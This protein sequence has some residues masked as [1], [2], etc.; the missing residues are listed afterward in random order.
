M[1]RYIIDAQ[2]LQQKDFEFELKVGMELFESMENTEFS[3]VD[4]TLKVVGNRLASNK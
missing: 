3:N 1:K 4:Y 2:T